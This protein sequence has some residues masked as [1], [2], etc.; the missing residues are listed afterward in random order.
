M[1]LSVGVAAPE[2]GGFALDG[3]LTGV[4]TKGL[5]GGATNL[6]ALP[7]LAYDTATF[8]G[9]AAFLCQ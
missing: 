6:F 8:L 9:A 2:A 7:K 4:M 3:G 5:L 1:L